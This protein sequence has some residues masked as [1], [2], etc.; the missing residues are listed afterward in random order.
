MKT[1]QILSRVVTAFVAAILIAT[2]TGRAQTLIY[3]SIS[4]LVTD[5]AGGAVPG[6]RISLIND[7]TRD[8][9]LVQT[10]SEGIYRFLNV[11]PATYHI[12]AVA[13]GFK[14]TVRPNV[15]IEVDKSAQVDLKLEIGAVT[16]KLEVKAT[17]PLLDPQTSSLGG[18]VQTRPLQELPLNGRNPLALV[19]LVP[20]VVPQQGSQTNPAG[21]NP[22]VTGN[23]Q[24][25]GGVAG[26]SQSY[27]DGA[28]LNLNYGNL[29]ALV[30]TQDTLAEFKVQTNSLSPEFGRTSG[31]VINMISRSGGNDFHGTVYEFLRNRVFNANTFF[32][33]QAG[34]VRPPF[35]QNQYGGAVGG[36]II[37]DK[38]FFFSNWE[39]YHQRT[40]QSLVMTVPTATMKAG[41]L[42]QR[43]VPA[44]RRSRPDL[45][46][47]D[48]M[49]TA[50]QSG[51]C[52]GRCRPS[53]TFPQQHDSGEP[54]QSGDQ[55]TGEPLGIAE[56]DRPGV[57]GS[58][59]LGRQR[60][61]RR[62]L[63]VGHST[64]RL[65]HQ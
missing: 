48:H 65:Q 32:N 16:E 25:G 47:A 23:F 31:G 30:P 57:Y 38:L 8:R 15:V 7:S 18:V 36:R 40:A 43:F 19:A 64:R 3:G 53:F 13:T 59:Q 22:F 1:T 6:A 4:G 61:V 58:E 20:S 46:P 5:S 62:G 9:R 33:N 11:L 10:S 55:D 37:R 50:Q 29:L 2:S 60:V 34:V 42:F 24:I 52:G 27:L 49:R 28:P 12:E 17:A 54:S 35:V 41:E 45:R 14:L 56:R 26:Q 51:L 21:Q 63:G 39:G 44:A